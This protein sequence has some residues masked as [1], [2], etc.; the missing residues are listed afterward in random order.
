ME[1]KNTI[2]LTVIAIA[3]LLVAVVGATFA[4][5]TAQ[6]T[7][8]NN[9]Q[10]TT[11]VKTAAL[12][13]ATMDMGSKVT[14]NDVYPGAKVVKSVN[15]KG[16]CEEGVASCTAVE[17][18]ISVTETIDRDI[19]GTDVEW[20]LYKS[21]DAFACRNVV[22]SSTS[23]PPIVSGSTTTTTNT[24][25]MVSTCKVGTITDATSDDDFKALPDVDF[26]TM[27]K[28]I[29]SDSANSATIPVDGTT[30]DNYYLVVTYKDNGNQ[31]AQQGQNFSIAINFAAK[32]LND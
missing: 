12:A 14:A 6:V 25:K 4:Y 20:A 2:L 28:V 27:T 19:F 29:S 7:T 17:A 11:D 30:N 31:N 13:S 1:K 10:N 15:V 21:K 23:E 32:S 5:F 3:T 24:Y 9:G 26:T 22:D 16:S 8:T 18:V